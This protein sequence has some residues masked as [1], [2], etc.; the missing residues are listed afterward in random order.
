MHSQAAR[1]VRGYRP[2]GRGRGGGA[3]RQAPATA[4]IFTT[5]VL[6]PYRFSIVSEF[7]RRSAH[8]NRALPILQLN[9]SGVFLP[10]MHFP[11]LFPQK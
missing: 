2:V 8:V 1:F 7:P 9:Y 5:K 6:E 10:E 3:S 11:E 4:F